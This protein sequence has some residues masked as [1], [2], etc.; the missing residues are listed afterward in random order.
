MKKLNSDCNLTAG[1]QNSR[2]IVHGRSLAS[3]PYFSTYA[4]A[5]AKVGG[6]REGKIRLGRPARFS[7]LQLKILNL[8][9]L[10]RRIFPS[11]PPPTFA[12][13]CAYAEKYG[14]PARLAWALV[15]SR[16][17]RIF[18]YAKFNARAQKGEG[19]ENIETRLS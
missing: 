6:G 13:A 18:P 3:Q 5:R 11:L 15:V 10:P 12:R 19:E 9:G 2:S 8:A 7:W 17:R 1:L 16:V 4:H 14:W